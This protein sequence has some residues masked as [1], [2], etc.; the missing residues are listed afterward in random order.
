MK[1][2]IFI[3]TFLKKEYGDMCL[4][5]LESIKTYYN[6]DSFEL[7]IFV[8]KITNSIIKTYINNNTDIKFKVKLIECIINS[9]VAASAYR[10]FLFDY[11][12]H[13]KFN[14]ILYLDT[15]ILINNSLDLVFAIDIDNKV[16]AVKENG[17]IPYHCLYHTKEEFEKYKTDDCFSAGILLFDSTLKKYIENVREF[18]L[19]GINSGLQIGCCIDQPFF[20]LI[21]HRMN[22]INNTQLG[23]YTKCNATEITT[24]LITHFAGNVGDHESKLS[25]MNSFIVQNKLF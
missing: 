21:A 24:Q 9:V 20:N 2:L 19:N 17:Q 15:D 10:M 12:D 6:N 18:F 7:Y 11:I 23:K 3:T 13:T 5:L 22:C 4:L 14:K 16:H 8:D 1:N 25:K